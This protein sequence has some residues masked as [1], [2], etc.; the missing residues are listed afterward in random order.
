[1]A[2]RHDPRMGETRPSSAV[3]H[4]A[5][6]ALRSTGLMARILDAAP[7]GMLLVGLDGTIVY[8]NRA[9]A[10]MVGYVPA[11]EHAFRLLDMADPADS[12]ALR[13]Q[14]ERLVRGEA[15][16][17]RGE[18][19]FRHQRQREL[20][21]RLAANRLE[22]KDGEP[23]IIILQLTDIE[24]QKKAEEALVY[25]EARWN[26]A[27]ESA[28]QGVWEHDIRTDTMFYS[29]MWRQMRGM[30]PDAEVDGNQEAW[31]SRIHPDDR[32]YIRANISR[33]GEDDRLLDAL[34]YRERIQDGSY[35]WILSRGRPSEWD[36]NGKALRTIGTDTDITRLKT[37]ELELAAEKERLH[38]TLQSIADGMISANAD[39]RVEFM[40]AAAEQLTGMP[41]AEARGRLVSD[42]F[43][44]RSDNSGEPLACPILD[45]LEK[46]Q[47]V[48]VEDDAI[49]Y[50]CDG[51][52]RDIRCTAAPVPGASGEIAG[53]VLVFQDVTQSRTLQRQLAHSAS[54]DALTGLVNRAAFERAL[55]ANVAAG[56]ANGRAS[57]LIY[58]DLDHFKPVN[59]TAGHAAGDALLKQ[60]AQTIRDSCRAHDVVGRIGGDEFAVLLESCPAESGLEVAGK[61]V[62]AVGAL[63]FTWAGR[64]YRIGASAGLAMVTVDSTSPLGFM[65]EADAACYAAKA[66]GRGRAVAF[67]DM[68]NPVSRNR[69]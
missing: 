19:R 26:T 50:C 30:A 11:A 29:R 59:D 67:S 17:W 55:E 64:Q 65:G 5:I 66:A 54:H 3:H 32:D 57:S 46:S 25:S 13:L 48:R 69:R 2:L 38:I 33:Q 56:R 42:V 6:P 15:R 1:M 51:K 58:V 8:S 21:V 39:G 37:V 49:L 34:E 45:C 68:V 63:I 22:G 27:L 61:I 44:L 12:L 28:R 43:R 36:E 53:A 40:N 10:D 62:R 18:Y 47:P 52:T 41:A 16:S 24:L 23:D 20:S 60:V 14:F 7:L 4:P 31:I 35:I 9:F